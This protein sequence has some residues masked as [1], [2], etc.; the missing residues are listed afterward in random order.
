MPFRLLMG[1]CLWRL[2]KCV[3]VSAVVCALCVSHQAAAG[4]ELSAKRGELS[5]LEATLGQR[6]AELNTSQE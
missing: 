6:T 3:C 5:A 4:A 1:T 2:Q